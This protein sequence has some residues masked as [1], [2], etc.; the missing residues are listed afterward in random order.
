MVAVGLLLR[1]V[2]G[3]V[4]KV[5]KTSSG[6][7]Q[8]ILYSLVANQPV[9]Y[10]AVWLQMLPFMWSIKLRLAG[11]VLVLLQCGLTPTVQVGNIWPKVK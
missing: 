5:S 3:E 2:P 10:C 1:H 7:G 8:Q 4:L 9:S 11:L 6:N